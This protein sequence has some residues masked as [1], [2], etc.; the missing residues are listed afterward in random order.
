MFAGIF[1]YAKTWEFNSP[2]YEIIL[3]V[4]GFFTAHAS[5]LTRLLISAMLFLVILWTSLSNKKFVESCIILLAAGLLLSPVIMPWYLLWLLPFL[6]L[7]Q[8]NVLLL[9]TG[10]VSVVY[11]A[12]IPLV[13]TGDWYLSVWTYFIEYSPFILLIV[14]K[15]IFKPLNKTK[16]GEEMK[17]QKIMRNLKKNVE[18]FVFLENN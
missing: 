2:I 10:T 12:I 8:N 11:L 17:N 6:A 15:F 13:Y 7:K 3:F 16:F 5:I 18:S 9:W 1:V 14:S 4:T